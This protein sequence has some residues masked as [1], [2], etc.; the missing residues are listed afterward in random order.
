VPSN[1]AER[2]AGFGDMKKIKD[3]NPINT[4]LLETPAAGM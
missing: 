1:P 3:K 2:F 4:F